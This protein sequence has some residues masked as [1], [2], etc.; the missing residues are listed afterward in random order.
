[1]KV[2]GVPIVAAPP[3]VCTMTYIVAGVFDSAIEAENFA[4][5]LATKFVRHLV[6]LRKHT[7]HV[8]A[9]SFVFVPKL[10]MKHRWTDEELYERYE[11][12]QA[13]IEFVESQLLE[14]TP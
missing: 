3:S 9:N 7:Q 1:M 4:I 12:T 2:T 8:T 10:D 11:L 6:S 13:E 5:Y 14:M